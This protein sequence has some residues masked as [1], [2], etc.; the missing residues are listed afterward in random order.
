M[1]RCSRK[2]PFIRPA[3][4]STTPTYGSPD[5]L[6]LRDI[7]NPVELSVMEQ[8]YRAVIEVLSGAPVTEV[9]ERYGVSPKTLR[10]DLESA[11]AVTAPG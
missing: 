10:G 8:R 2:A 3:C 11:E 7:D 5:V 9:T 4:R 6:E 1:T